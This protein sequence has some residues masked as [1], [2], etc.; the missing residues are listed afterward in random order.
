MLD[1]LRCPR[2]Q[3]NDLEAVGT[4]I[5]KGI[6]MRRY[7]CQECGATTSAA[8]E[9]VKASIAEAVTFH[10]LTCPA[11]ASADT[12]VTSTMR[13]IR[14]HKCRNCGQAFKSVEK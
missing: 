4:T 10:I 14:Y 6:P 3:C 1:D 11:C 5:L 8:R 2:C 7:H 9:R 13:P 12:F